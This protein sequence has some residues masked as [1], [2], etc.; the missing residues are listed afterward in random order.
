MA[1]ILVL[2]AAFAGLWAALG[3]ARTR[4]EIG[5]RVPDTEILLIGT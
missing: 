5:A 1:R 2:G 3:A 4:D